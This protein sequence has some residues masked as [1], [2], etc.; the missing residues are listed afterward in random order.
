MYFIF[1]AFS[2]PSSSPVILFF[3][4]AFSL[5]FWV[6]IFLSKIVRFLLPSVVDIFSCH[7][8]PIV[9]IISFRCFGKSCF[10]LYYFT[11]CR[12]LFNLLLSPALSGLIAQVVLLFFPV[13]PVP[14]SHL[15]LPLTFFYHSGLFSF[16]FFFF[17]SFRVKFL[18]PVLTFSFHYSRFSLHFLD[19]SFLLLIVFLPGCLVVYRSVVWCF[20]LPFIFVWIIFVWHHLMCLV[21]CYRFVYVFFG[22]L[23]I[24]GQKT[25]PS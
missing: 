18:I 15:F 14:F 2:C 23:V 13:L 5:C 11:L 8:L 17:F 16:F 10:V 7:S 20:H 3:H 9:D 1:G 21:L 22:F 19:L 4:T 6:A 24:Q 25:N 12:Y